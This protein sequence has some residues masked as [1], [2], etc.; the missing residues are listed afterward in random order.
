MSWV[1]NGTSATKNGRIV[2]HNLKVCHSR[3]YRNI[4]GKAHRADQALYAACA[5]T[6]I[7]NNCKGYIP[8][9]FKSASCCDY[10]TPQPCFESVFAGANGNAN[11]ATPSSADATIT[12]PNLSV[13]ATALSGLSACEQAT[14]SFTALSSA[15]QATCLCYNSGGDYAGAAFDDP[16]SSCVAFAQTADTSDYP[17][18]SSVLG[19][20][21]SFAG[22]QQAPQTSGTTG[23]SGNSASTGTGARV[24]SSTSASPASLTQTSAPQTSAA[25]STAST[26]QTV[27]AASGVHKIKTFSIPVLVLLAMTVLVRA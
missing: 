21:S 3:Q 27:A 18:L 4:N 6:G 15:A 2:H 11:L 9:A 13:C 7:C 10:A 12:D 5:F 22:Q 1:L 26:T 24:A 16:W 25:G 23:G 14:P 20:C 19:F 8:N 17:A